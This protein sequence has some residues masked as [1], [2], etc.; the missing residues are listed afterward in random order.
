MNDAP[1]RVE[2]ETQDSGPEHLSAILERLWRDW[3]MNPDARL[4]VAEG[5]HRSRQRRAA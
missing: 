3:T 4:A 1:G 2:P 5:C